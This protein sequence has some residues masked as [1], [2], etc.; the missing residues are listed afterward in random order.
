MEDASVFGLIALF[1]KEVTDP[2]GV[3]LFGLGMF[4]VGGDDQLRLDFFDGNG[5]L[6]E[7]VTSAIAIGFFGIVNTTG[8]ALAEVNFVQGN[9]FA[10]VD[11][12][13]T[14]ARQ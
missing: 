3:W 12:F 4:N 8:A 5:N 10:P 11:D 14:A 6:L 13:Q 2:E 7:S 1:F 9:G